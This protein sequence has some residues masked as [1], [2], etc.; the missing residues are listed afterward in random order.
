MKKLN[1]GQGVIEY[2]IIF[3]IAAVLSVVMFASVRGYF[4]NYVT[5]ATNSM[6]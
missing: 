6:R 1:C 3:A 5:S 4:N 2:A